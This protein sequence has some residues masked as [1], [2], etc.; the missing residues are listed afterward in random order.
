MK[1]KDIE[2]TMVKIAKWTI[3]YFGNNHVIPYGTLAVTGTVNGGTPVTMM[4]RRKCDMVGD[5]TPQYTT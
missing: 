3:P 1:E 2:I 5:T 4:C